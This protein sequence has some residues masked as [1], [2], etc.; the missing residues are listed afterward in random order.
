MVLRILVEGYSVG[1]TGPCYD[2]P[3]DDVMSSVMLRR[4]VLTL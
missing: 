3:V 1:M 2:R 4:T